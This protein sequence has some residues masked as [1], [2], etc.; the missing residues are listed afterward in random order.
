MNVLS[1]LRILFNLS[2][3][4]C[5]LMAEPFYFLCL[6]SHPTNFLTVLLTYLVEWL[7]K[8]PIPTNYFNLHSYTE[9]VISLD[10]KVFL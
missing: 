7:L 6:N 4:H 3:K 2:Q 5:L 9:E 10:I 8:K 1:N